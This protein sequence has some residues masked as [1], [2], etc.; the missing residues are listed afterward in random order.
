MRTDRK[1]NGENKKCYLAYSQDIPKVGQRFVCE[2]IELKNRWILTQV[3][4]STVEKIEVIDKDIVKIETS[5]SIYFVKSGETRDTR[6]Y[7]ATFIEDP[8]L[9]ARFSCMQVISEKTFE[10]KV[11]VAS[12]VRSIKHFHNL[13]QVRTRNSVYFVATVE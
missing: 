10:R 8:S 4:T 7:F 6:N 5:A 1:T 3:K 11:R 12:K 2:R 13:L 9:G